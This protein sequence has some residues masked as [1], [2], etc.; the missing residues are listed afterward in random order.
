M[1]SRNPKFEMF[2]HGGFQRANIFDTLRMVHTQVAEPELAR[3]GD[4][5]GELGE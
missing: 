3:V 5:W 4:V 2:Q 1:D